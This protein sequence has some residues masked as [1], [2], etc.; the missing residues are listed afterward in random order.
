MAHLRQPRPTVA[1][2]WLVGT[3]LQPSMPNILFTGTLLS[4]SVVHFLV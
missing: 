3:S 2:L 4:L 1:G